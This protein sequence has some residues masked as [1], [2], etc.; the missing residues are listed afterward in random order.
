[1]VRFTGTFLKMVRYAG[2]DGARLAPLIVGDRLPVAVAL[3]PRRR[4]IRPGDRCCLN[5]W[6]E[7]FRHGTWAR[8]L[9]AWLAVL[10]AW[11]GHPGPMA[12]A[13]ADHGP[14]RAGGLLLPPSPTLRSNS[15]SRTNE[16]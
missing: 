1:M 7:S 6:Q 11:R 4:S 10:A 2:G 12:L 15:S 8:L 3:N 9:G 5:R 14:P 13:Y 16:P